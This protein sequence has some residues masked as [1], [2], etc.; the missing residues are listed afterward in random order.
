MAAATAS[1]A[2]EAQLL[3]GQQKVIAAEATSGN[4]LTS[5]WR[6]ITMLT[7]L[8][9]TVADSLAWLPNRLAP[10]AWQLLQ[11]GLGGYVVGRSVEK[12]APAIVT[13]MSSVKSR[14]SDT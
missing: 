10:E 12:V 1:Q 2:Y 11:L 14:G 7:F 9:L 6:P 4:W 8:G 3:D 13:A 5:S